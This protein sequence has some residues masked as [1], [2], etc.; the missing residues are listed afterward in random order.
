MTPLPYPHPD[1]TQRLV[2]AYC[3]RVAEELAADPARV[4]A[5]AA[6]NLER[7]APHCHP[8][9]IAAWRAVLARPAADLAAFLVSDEP[10][11]AELRRNN[12][13]AGVLPERE[14]QDIVR[15]VWRAPA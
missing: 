7:M 6:A 10:A 5:K 13:F 2:D 14:R 8:R 1:R 15:Q 9:L 11:A 4:T 3:R 12:P